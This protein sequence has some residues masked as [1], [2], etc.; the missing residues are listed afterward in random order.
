M[1]EFLDSRSFG[2]R[3]ARDLPRCCSFRVAVSYIR[4]SGIS[5]LLKA[6]SEQ[7]SRSLI[8]TCTDFGITEPEALRALLKHGY[9]L[10]AFIAPGLHAKVWLLRF[11]DREPIV[12]VGS[13]NLSLSAVSKNVEANVRVD[14]SESVAKAT[15]WFE[16]LTHPGITVKI[17]DRWI[18]EYQNLRALAPPQERI[19]PAGHF[20]ELPILS[21]SSDPEMA[22]IAADERINANGRWYRRGAGHTF[23]TQGIPEGL[24][25]INYP[26]LP[27]RGHVSGVRLIF[28][29]NDKHGNFAVWKDIPNNTLNASRQLGTNRD[30]VKDWIRGV[31]GNVT[32]FEY[33]VA[34]GELSGI[35][36]I[37]LRPRITSN[38]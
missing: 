6:S 33:E 20:V 24:V 15:V 36:T 28:L 18:E 11:L 27:E 38:S 3:L 21:E 7:V 32:N 13:S 1:T 22:P 29:V 30:I 23:K 16:E 9:D 34:I 35:P 17:N 8:I 5:V 26:R 4:L 37:W 31:W 25:R 2:E 12:F 10:R 19:I 14:Q